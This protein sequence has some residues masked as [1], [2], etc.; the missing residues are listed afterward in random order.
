MISFTTIKEKIEAL[1]WRER[2]I[3]VGGGVLVIFLFI[4]FLGVSPARERSQVLK[5]LISQKERELQELLV[6][7]DEYQKLKGAEDAI[8]RRTMA[9]GAG[10][11]PISILEGLARKA[12]VREQLDQMRPLPS[13][14]APRYTIIPVQLNIRG[15]GLAEIVA[16]IYEIEN[17]DAPFLIKRLKLRPTP[18]GGGRLDCTLEVLTFNVGVGR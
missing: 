3:V 5:R 16:Y 13:I 1:S 18:R 11:S 17:A 7:C 9:L 2:L 4:Y 14:S 10:V 8:V 15:A 6:I 12:G